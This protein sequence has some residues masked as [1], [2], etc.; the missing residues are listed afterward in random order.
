[1]NML[2][3]QIIGAAAMLIMIL[4]VQC[5]KKK[6]I[7]LVQAISNLLYFI[8]YILLNAFSAATLNLITILR[9]IC[10]YSYDKKNKNIPTW[11]L[12]LFIII[13]LLIGKFVYS[14]V[15]D[16]I[17]IFITVMYTIGA[18]CK[19]TNNFR[20]VFLGCSFLWIIYNFSVNAFVGVFGNIFEIVSIS[21]ALYRY[22]N[23]N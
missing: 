2:Y 1:M 22:K 19:N 4:S 7:L 16:L 10:F 9:N 20:K 5:N 3:A 21:I 15:L 18:S 12:I 17:P 11:L 13:I 14:N 8:Q 6:N 23:N